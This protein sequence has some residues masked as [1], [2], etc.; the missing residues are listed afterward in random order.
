EAHNFGS[1]GQNHYNS[2]LLP[3]SLSEYQ[4]LL[5]HIDVACPSG[6][7]DPWDQPAN[8][9]AVTD[10]GSFEIARYTTPFG[11]ACGPWTVD[12][13][14]FK[15]LLAGPVTFHSYV[16]V[17]GQSGWL[18]TI[19]LELIEGNDPTPYRRISNLWSTDYWVYGDPGINDDLPIAEVDVHPTTETSHVRMTITGHG[20]GN[21]NNAA[22]FYQTTHQL[23]LNGSS[24][25]NHN[26][27]KPDCPDNSCSDQQ[28]TWLFPRAGWCPGQEVIPYIV[29]T[30]G[31]ADP[32]STIEL[33]YELADY[34]NALNTGYNGGSH[35]EPHFRIWSYFVESSST[36]YEDYLNLATD[37]ITPT[38][39]GTGAGE[40]LDE[41]TIT[42]SNTGNVPMSDFTVS[43]FINN[44]LFA[45]DLIEM[46]LSVGES[47]T[48]TFSTLSGFNPGS[49]N[50]FFGVVSHPDD[51]NIGDDVAKDEVGTP[52]STAEV[53]AAL[54]AVQI[55]PNPSIDRQV[56]VIVPSTLVGSNF[57]LLT[58]TGQNVGSGIITSE[59]QMLQIP[60]AG[61][62][63]LHL[64]TEDGAVTSRKLTIIE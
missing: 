35:T 8:I 3:A 60:Q 28:G 24:I 13:T 52:S 50:V 55:F 41:L 56:Q 27:W 16:Q 49:Q 39:S 29:N 25:D 53:E 7:C 9:S 11:I 4:T 17:W 18:V 42:I 43:Y 30:T 14:D 51:E 26:L 1:G 62:F 54:R 31:T 20:Q 59:Q 19:D 34:T 47:M 12:V 57:Q 44:E 45:S 58:A 36:P 32:G 21:T 23:Q 22:E 10:A 61:V 33:D 38:V 63:F 15:G 48:H 64:Q 46:T 40:T 37:A 2:V 6:G 5:L